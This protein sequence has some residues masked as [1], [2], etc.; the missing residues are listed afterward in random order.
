M[1]MRIFQRTILNIDQSSSIFVKYFHHSHNTSIHESIFL[2]SKTLG[3]FSNEDNFPKRKNISLHQ[4]MY[5]N[6]SKGPLLCK[7]TPV[8][9]STIPMKLSF[10]TNSVRH[11]S[12]TAPV[13]I[14]QTMTYN[15]GVWKAISESLP[16]E[17][18]TNALKIMHDQTGLPWWATIVLST[19]IMRMCINLPLTIHD[20]SITVALLNLL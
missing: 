1:I 5:N 15:N 11:Y 13:I 14:N 3:Y 4:S 18:L 2:K 19:I 17:F 6:V 12:N 20:V 8:L 7:S 10:R 16:V 9:A